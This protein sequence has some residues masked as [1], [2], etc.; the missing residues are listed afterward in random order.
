LNFIKLRLSLRS[1]K[2][3]ILIAGD[4]LMEK[5]RE[6]NAWFVPDGAS[7][8]VVSAPVSSVNWTK[9]SAG[10]VPVDPPSWEGGPD[11]GSGI[12]ESMDPAEGGADA[13]SD[14]CGLSPEQDERA[15]LLRAEVLLQEGKITE[16]V[17][18]LDQLLLRNPKN[19]RALSH[20]GF[21]AGSMKSWDQAERFYKWALEF[22]SQCD[23]ALK[24]LALVRSH[25]GGSP[26]R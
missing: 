17:Q 11:A 16:A 5:W 19:S 1:L 26:G 18:L 8:A 24:G 25:R 23:P 9:M 4:S 7:P 22:D 21:L 10:K 6:A 20:M 15:L 12:M 3:C 13:P 14:S 2:A